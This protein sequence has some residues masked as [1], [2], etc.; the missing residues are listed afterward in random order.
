MTDL[1]ERE[2]GVDAIL[3]SSGTTLRSAMAHAPI[4]D[5]RRPRGS[6]RRRWVIAVATLGVLIAGLVAVG[7]NRNDQSVGND[8][9]RLHYLVTSPPDG[10]PLVLVS[11]P[12]TQRG[13]IGATV[14]MNYY[15]TEAAPLGPILSVNGSAGSPDLE[16]VPAANGT[17]FQETTIDGRRAAFANGENGQRLLYIEDGGHW[18]VLTARNIDDATLST[19]AA[20]AIRD[21]NG[22][23]VVPTAALLDGLTLVV[24]AD[25]PVEDLT[26]GTNFSGLSYANPDGRSIGLEV[27]PTRLSAR[28]VFGLQANLTATKVKGADGFVGS[29]SFTPS[30][31]HI[32]VQLLLWE[33]DGLEFRMTGFNVTGTQMMIAAE[34][35]EPASD[36]E[37]N[38]MLRQT[39]LATIPGAAPAQT[40]P[41]E[42]AS[43]G[44]DPPFTGD[45]KDVSIDVSV[46]DTS[47]NEQT[48]SGILPT[49]ERWKVEVKRVFDSISMQPEVDGL[50]QG[51]A[52]GPVA[53]QPG[54]EFGCCTPLNVITADTN[55]ATMRVTT[56][57]G[58][59]FTIPLHDLP[60]TGGL[61]IAVV[62]LAN[63]SGPQLAELLD[64]DGNVLDSQP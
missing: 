19:M 50:P 37:W 15:A 36:A 14:D 42:P 4:P 64:A 63:G 54:E 28:A 56:H 49:G 44:T 16:V 10:L 24:P 12:G 20:A 57:D 60:G 38:G 46:T 9:S 58:D 31:P 5:F 22:S 51:L 41:A 45:V 35:V 18:A 11:E 29:Y 39:G 48:W 7:T 27:Y 47:P 6:A 61:R 43:P 34:S 40:V 3:R 8:P 33:R 23:A 52:Y 2:E 26:F 1:D 17:N 13:P 25:A 62:A 21:A 55:A 32:D 30:V 53:R 59:R